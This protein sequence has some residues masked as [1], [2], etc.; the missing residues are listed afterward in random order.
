MKNKLNITRLT[1]GSIPN[2]SAEEPGE[3][4]EH[5]TERGT[6]TEDIQL[7]LAHHTLASVLLP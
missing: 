4:H 1:V 3:N 2:Y 5:K 6:T 7:N